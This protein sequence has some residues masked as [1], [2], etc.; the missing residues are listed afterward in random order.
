MTGRIKFFNIE[1]G[2]G[3]IERDDGKEDVFVHI[4]QIKGNS[5]VIIEGARVKFD[6]AQGNKG[7]QALNVIV[8]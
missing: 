2:F 7:V 6:I 1:K 5:S 4:S 8:Y 3:F